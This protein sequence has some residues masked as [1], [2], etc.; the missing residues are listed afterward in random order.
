M[1]AKDQNPEWLRQFETKTTA[2]VNPKASTASSEAVIAGAKAGVAPA[3]AAADVSQSQASAASSQ[4]SAART[5]ALTPEELRKIQL[6]NE[7]TEAAA[8]AARRAAGTKAASDTEAVN[9]ILERIAEAR[10]LVSGWS[11][12]FGSY[13]GDIPTTQ[14]RSLKGL[15]GPEGT[16]SANILLRTMEQMRASSA[17]GATGLGAMDRNENRTLKNSIDNLDLGRNP[18]EVLETLNNIERKFRRYSAITSGYNP[19]DREVAL[20]F[21]LIPPED[22]EGGEGI[23]KGTIGGVTAEENV[24]RP[25]ERR[26]LNVT[27][28]KML[29]EGRSA[30]DIKAYLDK[31]E[32]GL[33]AKTTNLEWW[34]TE[35]KK[36]KNK[37]GPGPEDYVDV[38]TLRTE[39]SAPEKAI[40]EF[41]QTG[42]GT[43]LL[44]ATDFAT[45]GAIPSLTGDAQASRA[46][47]K[48]AELER[49]G[50]FTAG[51][52]IGG[53]TGLTGAENLAAKYGL[54]LSPA[55]M[56]ALQSGLYGFGASDK[57]GLAAVPDAVTSA[58]TGGIGGKIGDVGGQTLGR[59]VS[60]I[61]DKTGQVLGGTTQAIRDKAL[62][63]LSKRNIP[64][65]LGEIVGPRAQKLESR[66]S[67]LPIVGPAISARLGEGT[68]AFN[69][70]AFKESLEGLGEKYADF[71]A[72]VGARGTRNARK[73]VSQAFTDALSGVTLVQDNVFQRNLSNAWTE[74]GQL[75]DVG[76]KMLKAL[77]DELGDLLKPGRNLTGEE[78]Q[79]ALGKVNKIGRSFKKNELFETSIAPRLNAVESEIRGVVE[80]QAPDVLPQFDAARGAWRKV[81]V[82]GDAVKRATPKEGLDTRGVFTPEQL[83]AAAMAN[84][85]KFTGKGSSVT[86]DYPFQGLTE[87]GLD[88]LTPRGRTGSTMGLPLA[89]AGLIGAGGYFAQPG[90]ETN[91]MTGEISGETRDAV[92]PSLL[93]ATGATLAGI[94]YSRVGQNALNKLMFDPRGPNTEIIGNLL[95]KYG[96][97]ALAGGYGGLLG[98]RPTS[99]TP[100][101]TGSEEV[102]FQPVTITPQ[103]AVVEPAAEGAAD[104]T[105]AAPA[106]PT[107]TRITFEGRDVDYDPETDT[108]VELKTG[109]RV[110]ELAELRTPPVG[111][112]RGGHVQAFRNG[113]MASI[114]DMAR[115]YGTRR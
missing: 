76:P 99:G 93:A 33:G 70:A 104:E 2:P 16:I 29:R 39:A 26:G 82:L 95:E 10:R 31:V 67:Q 24:E 62:A 72:D 11:T 101:I 60:G 80:R 50:A 57:E 32:P 63:E 103:V 20:Q 71:G 102:S 107:K 1:A 115:H 112:Y 83:Q 59:V 109:R 91:P 65:T 48:G 100:D 7:A 28:S 110:K 108:Y 36:P 69:R 77:N 18:E 25:P 54:N 78:V 114:A 37:Q 30:A 68:E 98:S 8:A 88:V 64:L 19:D 13:L 97:R 90:Q 3:A 106:V 73:N 53:I 40:G 105:A 94:P 35:L 46:A 56:A 44:G 9:N 111:M 61:R 4:A 66:L 79:A 6:E 27:V 17:A 86:R 84:A 55:V 45:M 5:T 85:E 23:P 89:T 15:L 14:A 87:A 52:M 43:A 81:S 41:A 75:P 92:L 49:P 21:G 58:I 38:E 113:G 12:G 51:Q 74:L 22:K 96:P 47:I 42:V 34:E